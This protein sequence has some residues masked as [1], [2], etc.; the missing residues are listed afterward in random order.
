MGVI[1]CVNGPLVS[2][3][4]IS[5]KGGSIVV[6]GSRP[7]PL[8]AFSGTAAIIGPD[9]VEVARGALLAF[10]AAARGDMLTLT[11]TLYPG[12]CYPVVPGGVL[13]A[14]PATLAIGG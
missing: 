9:G 11:V 10:E 4:S 1:E 7:G 13:P 2:V 5:F 14:A 3:E 12:D 6:T 8:R